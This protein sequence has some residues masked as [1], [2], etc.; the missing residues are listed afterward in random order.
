MDN[1]I[2]MFGNDFYD[3]PNI[4][5]FGEPGAR[6]AI[7]LMIRAR[8]NPDAPVTMFRALPKD[9]PDTINPGDWVSISRDYAVQHGISNL[10]DDFKVIAAETRAGDLWTEGNSVCEWGYWGYGASARTVHTSSLAAAD[11]FADIVWSGSRTSSRHG[12]VLIIQ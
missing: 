8:G 12:R 2:G 7:Q 10:D 5:N 4:Y 11:I 1:V 9:A 6:E 3:R